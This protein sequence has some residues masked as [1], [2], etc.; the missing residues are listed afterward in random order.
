[1]LQNLSHNPQTQTWNWKA[2][3]SVLQHT[4]NDFMTHDYTGMNFFG[5]TLVLG[6]S[7]AN[8]V[9]PEYY[10]KIREIFPRAQI[11]MLDTGHYIHSEKPNEFV[12]KVEQFIA[13]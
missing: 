4:L 13:M 11:E 10:P 7:R 1:V 5:P 9:K 6:G 12:Q 2:N 3:I 8:Y